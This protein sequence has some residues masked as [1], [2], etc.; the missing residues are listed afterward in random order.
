VLATRFLDLVGTE[1]SAILET[2]VEIAKL[3]SS[4]RFRLIGVDV[5][6]SIFTRSEQGYITPGRQDRI[7]HPGILVD[8]DGQSVRANE[9]DHVKEEVSQAFGT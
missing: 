2:T 8:T 4:N 7:F 6:E 1:I 3:L 9:S 5:M